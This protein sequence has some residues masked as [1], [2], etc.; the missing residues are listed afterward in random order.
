MLAC[1]NYR[2]CILCLIL[3]ETRPPQKYLFVYCFLIIPLTLNQTQPMKRRFLSPSLRGQIEQEGLFGELL[4]DYKIG[5]CCSELKKQIK[6]GLT[7]TQ[8]Q[9]HI[10]SGGY[11]LHQNLIT[12][13]GGPSNSE[14]R[15]TINH[16]TR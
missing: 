6:Q 14:F 2:E 13:P 16:S 7:M 5:Q 4:P 10:T 3:W 11:F 1:Q 9:S 12:L 15:S 8:M